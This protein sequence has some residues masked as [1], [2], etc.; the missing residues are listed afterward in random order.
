MRARR[1]SD[2]IKERLPRSAALLVLAQIMAPVIAV[3]VVE[4]ID[5]IYARSGFGPGPGRSV[6][7]YPDPLASFPGTPASTSNGTVRVDPPPAIALITP[8]TPPPST[9][10]TASQKVI[11][12]M[13]RGSASAQA[14]AGAP[15]PSIQARLPR[16]TS[17]TPSQESAACF[18]PSKTARISALSPWHSRKHPSASRVST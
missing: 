4:D 5:V 3:R 9:N 13:G 1:V 6:I 12:P 14:S 7:G 17:V 18:Q 10:S 11:A 8:A 15:G 2:L 16:T